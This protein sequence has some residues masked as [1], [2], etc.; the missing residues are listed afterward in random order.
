MNSE[1]F[2]AECIAQEDPDGFCHFV[3]FADKEFDTQVYLT[4]QR[5]FE[6][7]EQDIRLGMDTY[8]VEWCGQ[9]RSEYGGIATFILQPARVEV[10]FT[11]EMAQILGVARL[12]ISFELGREQW[13]SLQENLGHI[14]KDTKCLVVED[15]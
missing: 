12:A 1:T 14:F 9:E 15:A 5:S 7:D 4:L 6:H 3:G 2:H 8:H 10:F 13:L 11:E